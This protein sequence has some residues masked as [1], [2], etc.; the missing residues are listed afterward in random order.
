M[1]CNPPN[2]RAMKINI[3]S[4]LDGTE[5]LSNYRITDS[6]ESATLDHTITKMSEL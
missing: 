5:H 3:I 6:N 2:S 1:K 4:A